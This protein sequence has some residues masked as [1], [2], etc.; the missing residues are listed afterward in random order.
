MLILFPVCR[1]NRKSE[2]S[3]QL[4]FSLSGKENVCQWV[5]QLAQTNTHSLDM[6]WAWLFKPVL[7]IHVYNRIL[8]FIKEFVFKNLY[9][10][11]QNTLY[12]FF[13]INDETILILVQDGYFCIVTIALFF[14]VSVDIRKNPLKFLLKPITLILNDSGKGKYIEYIL[15]H[16]VSTLDFLNY[17]NISSWIQ[18]HWVW[19]Q[20][21]IAL[22]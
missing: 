12:Y 21:Y 4:L 3:E 7:L 14:N 16:S 19:F 15:Y 8:L 22:F 13:S 10:T 20:S 18:Q 5:S 2:T 17:C 11:L 6:H 9:Q 1:R